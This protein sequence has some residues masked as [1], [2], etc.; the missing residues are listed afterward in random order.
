MDA[1]ASHRVRPSRTLKRGKAK[2]AARG[3]AAAIAGVGIA[4]IAVNSAYAAQ[5]SVKLEVCNTAQVAVMTSLTAQG[6]DENGSPVTTQPQDLSP[7]QCSTLG[8]KWQIGTN[9]VIAT[10]NG[11]SQQFSGAVTGEDG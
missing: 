5:P 7:G 3:A 1:N 2:W 9:L 4:A 6:T 11:Q 10:Y 8:G